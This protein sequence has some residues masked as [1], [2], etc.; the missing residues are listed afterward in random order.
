MNQQNAHTWMNRVA[1][2]DQSAI[3]PL[4]E[5]LRPLAERSARRRL[6]SQG[7]WQDVAQRALIRLF[8]EA[9]RWRRTGRVESWCLALVYWEC[10]SEEKRLQRNRINVEGFTQ[11]QRVEHQGTQQHP[12]LSALSAEERKYMAAF[13][14]SLTAEE[15][16]ML[17]LQE[18][19]L[20]NTLSELSP[21]T[22]RKRKQ[23]LVQKLRENWRLIWQ[24]EK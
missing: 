20:L 24:E 21:A 22:F 5:Y 7:D 15:K 9:P 12:E 11:Q 1:D 18:N 10:R 13:I 23:R 14:E 3:S 4:Y 16:E 17:G 6:A 8:E 2:G 19:E